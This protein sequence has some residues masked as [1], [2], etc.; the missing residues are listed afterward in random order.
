MKRQQCDFVSRASFVELIDSQPSMLIKRRIISISDTKEERD[1]MVDKL[2]NIGATDFHSFVFNDD[3]VGMDVESAR[4]IFRLISTLGSRD[5]IVHCFAGVSRSGAIAKFANEY[6]DIGHFYLEDYMG[7]NRVVFDQL[8]AQAGTSMAAFY[9][10][11]ERR[12][13]SKMM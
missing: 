4:A 7:H 3:D 5:L 12:D 2:C 1:E 8:H 10:D 6:N 9:E 13:R 11:L